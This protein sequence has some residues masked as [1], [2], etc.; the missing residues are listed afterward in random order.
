VVLSL[1]QAIKMS[2]SEC[3][4]RMTATAYWLFFLWILVILHL[5]LSA[6]RATL[7]AEYYRE[8]SKQLKKI[9]DEELS[10]MEQDKVV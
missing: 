1:S 2:E 5:C 8:L 7:Q 6:A 4:K 10:A 3:Q 9:E